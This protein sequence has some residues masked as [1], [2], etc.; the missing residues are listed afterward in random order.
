[1]LQQLT[2]E[3]IQER[4]EIFFTILNDFI[5]ENFEVDEDYVMTEE[6]AYVTSVMLEYFEEN[7]KFPTLK[8]SALEAITGYDINTPL[9]EEMYL[10]LLDESIGK[11]VAGARYGIQNFLARK[12]QERLSAKADVARTKSKEAAATAKETEKQFKADTKSGSFGTGVKGAFKKAYASGG[13]E[14]AVA[15]AKKAKD[16]AQIKHNK[17][18]DARAKASGIESKREGLANKIDTGISNIKNR[19]KSAVTTGAQRVGGILGRAFG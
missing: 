18:W 1:M 9:Y 7:F 8:E 15:K 5:E 16:I 19:V 17:Q 13:V 2:E 4:E 3:Q 10:A 12:N 11:F 6:D 14:K